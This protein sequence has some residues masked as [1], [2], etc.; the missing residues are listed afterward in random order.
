[1]GFGDL[2][3]VSDEHIHVVVDHYTRVQDAIGIKC[4]LYPFH[5]RIYVGFPFFF[6]EWSHIASGAVFSLQTSFILHRYQITQV[7]HERGVFLY[8]CGSIHIGKYG[9]MYISVQQV[10]PHYRIIISTFH[11]KCPDICQRIAQYL[12]PE[13]DILND[14]GRMGWAGGSC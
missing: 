9:E 5:E 11:E 6:H 14:A 8:S 10:A 13:G 2:F 7:I 1:M 3:Q 4:L 12:S